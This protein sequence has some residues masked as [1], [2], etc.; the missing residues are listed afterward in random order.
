ME[1]LES[2]TE[3]DNLN[4]SC[5]ENDIGDELKIGADETYDTRSEVSSSSTEESDDSSQHSVNSASSKSSQEGNNRHRTRTRTKRS[6]STNSSGSS[7]RE[8]KRA[9]SKD[10]HRVV[11]KNY[12]YVTKLNYLFRDARCETV[13]FHLKLLNLHELK[14]CT[15]H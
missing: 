9:R 2:S 4:L 5:S 3:G 7:S 8:S 14:Y 10:G 13:I 11:S 15:C 6:R 1:G 12:D